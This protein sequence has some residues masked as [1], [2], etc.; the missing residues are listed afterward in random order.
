MPSFNPNTVRD[1]V[2]AFTPQRPARFHEL[3]AAREVIVE[4]RQKRASY[5]AIAELLTQHCL[6][7]SKTA[8]A[9]FCHEVIGEVVRPRRRA[10]RKR[11]VRRQSVAAEGK[12]IAQAADPIPSKAS[13]GQPVPETGAEAVPQRSRGP[14]IAQVRLIQSP[15][16]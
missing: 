14:R 2:A 4:L 15:P 3:S 13:A 11:T 1:A 6:P 9:A 16:K 8:V 10:P 12:A 7:I 5:R